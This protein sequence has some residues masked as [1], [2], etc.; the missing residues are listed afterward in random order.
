MIISVMDIFYLCM[1]C[2]IF[3]FIIHLE[4][5]VSTIKTMIE[6]FLEK[7]NGKAIKDIPKKK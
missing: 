5:Q 6:S 7:R 3:G 2:I 4:A 1:I